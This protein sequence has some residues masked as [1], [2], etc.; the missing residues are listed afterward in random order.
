MDRAVY[1]SPPPQGGGY[2][3]PPQGGGYPPP[4][5]GGGYPPPPQGGGYPPPP[6]SGGYPP[7]GG[8]P[9]AGGYGA[10]QQ[11]NVGDAFSWAWN[12]FSKNAAPLIV[13]TL[14]YGL[15][16]SAL[17]G[18]FLGLAFAVS[19]APVTTYETYDTGFSYETSSSFG[20]AS[21]LMLSL[22]GLVFMIVAAA[23]S[24]AYVS[25]LLDI[26]DGRPVAIGDFFKPRNFGSVLVAGVIV[27]VATYIGFA[28]CVI[29]G[30]IV[31]FLTIFTTFV[32]LDRNLAPIDAIKASSQIARAHV[33]D[34]IIAWLLSSLIVAV[35]VAVCYIGIIV[36]GP[37]GAL[38][39]TYSY[40][41]ISGGQVAPA[42]P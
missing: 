7:P 12:K 41:R 4:P 21:Y 22:G 25:S 3:P 19:P 27:G 20:V 37:I 33:G 28:L 14:V 10:D 32:L 34:T 8:Y 16:L 9:P 35:G 17:Y 38:F 24:S 13:A 18:I 30:L 42:T 29:P 5:Q 6:Q 1:Q 15:I 11:Y 26:A 39:M 23:I 2:P 36:T 40:R 31:G